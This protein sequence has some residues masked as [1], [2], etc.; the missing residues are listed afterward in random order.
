[1]MTRTTAW[2]SSPSPWMKSLPRKSDIACE[3][4]SDPGP[5]VHSLVNRLRITRRRSMLPFGSLL[6]LEDARVFEGNPADFLDNQ[7][8]DRHSRSENEIR[9]PQVDNLQC[10]RA[11]E[12][13]VHGWRREMDQDPAPCHAT[14]AL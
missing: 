5:S 13:R 10:Q 3:S 8:G 9:R 14:P 2:R 1:M 11:V 6:A 4:A 7:L 12:S